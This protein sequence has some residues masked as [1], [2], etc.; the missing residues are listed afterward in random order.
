MKFIDGQEL[1]QI[2]VD[3]KYIYRDNRTM[4]TV[5]IEDDKSIWF[6]VFKDGKIAAK[7]NSIFVQSV[8]F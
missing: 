5:T 8:N 7:Y 1:Y 6:S 4:I 2:Y 3:G